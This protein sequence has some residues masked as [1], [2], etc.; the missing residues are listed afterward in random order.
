KV[1]LVEQLAERDPERARSLMNQLQD[2][3]RSAIED[4]RALAHGI[5]PPLLSS[6]GLGVALSA[7]CRRAALSAS[8]DADGVGR[9]P[10]EV[11]AAARVPD[12]R[13][14]HICIAARARVGSRMSVGLVSPDGNLPP[15]DMSTYYMCA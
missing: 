5:Y 2:D 6:A 7:A 13:P 10:P 1:R 14:A 12:L 11:E 3:V 15:T 4:L 8:A 9:Y